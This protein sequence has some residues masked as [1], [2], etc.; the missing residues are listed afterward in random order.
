MSAGSFFLIRKGREASQLADGK[1]RPGGR[2]FPDWYLYLRFPGVAPT[3]FSTGYEICGKCLASEAPAQDRE[4]CS[5]Q[6][7]P[8]EIGKRRLVAL[9]DAR[10]SVG[11]AAADLPTA[12]RQWA[13]IGEVCRAYLAWHEARFSENKDKMKWVRRVIGDLRLVVAHARDLWRDDVVKWGVKAGS[14]V[15]DERRIDVLPVTALNKDMVRE[16]FRVRQG[17]VFDPSGR[18]EGNRAI[19]FVLL[20]A[21]TLFSKG[22]RAYALEKVRI[23]W[24][25]LGDF[26]THPLLKAPKDRVQL[27]ESSAW[28][29]MVT[30]AERVLAA[31]READEAA[32]W[33]AL[34]NRLLRRTGMRSKELVNARAEWIIELGGRWWIDIRDRAAVGDV[35]AFQIKG[36]A[37]PGLL[38][39]DAE[40]AVLLRKQGGWFIGHE[41]REWI[42]RVEHN[43]YVKRFLG[44]AGT[45]AQGNHRLRD[46]VAQYLYTLYG[47]TVAKEALRHSDARTTMA[48]YAKYRSDVPA[49]AAVEL[50]AWKPNV[51]G[52]RAG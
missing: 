52:M 45:R 23:P 27:V 14:R 42:V 33:V 46:F 28:D 16:Y 29:L 39:L 6:K 10:W 9:N 12:K 19:N 38:P 8:R 2:F 44:G 43:A 11:G 4:G 31:G 21:R 51:V 5:C 18:D 48:S 37:N 20:H 22:S 7:K 34:V 30:D 13:T 47:E 35:P 17:G 36:G 49:S 25:Q 26:L 24:E 41:R 40:T 32:Y 15:A 1:A 3:S 50:A